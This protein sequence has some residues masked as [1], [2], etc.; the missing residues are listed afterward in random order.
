LPD[1]TIGKTKIW[2]HCQSERKHIYAAYAEELIKNGWAYYAFD[3]SEA[4]EQERKEQEKETI[5]L[6]TIIPTENY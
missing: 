5:P 4:L 3:S 2:S 1:E 6:Y